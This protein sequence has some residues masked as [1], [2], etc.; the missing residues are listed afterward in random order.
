MPCSLKKRPAR[1]LLVR[2]YRDEMHIR[3]CKQINPL[4]S[5]QKPIGY[6]EM[7]GISLGN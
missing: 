5:T 2:F 3:L 4:F 1:A 6:D 7:L